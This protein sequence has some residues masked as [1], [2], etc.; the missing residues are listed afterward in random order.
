M[1]LLI[2]RRRRMFKLTSML[3]KVVAVFLILIMVACESNYYPK[4]HAYIRIDLPEKSY[5]SFDSNYPYSF[6]Y[7]VYATI[8]PN[9][10]QNA[11]PF[12]IDINF[13]QFQG[14]LHISYKTIDNNLAEYLEDS[15]TL[16]MKHIPKSS[17]IEN[18]MYENPERKV[19][20]LTYNIS[21]VNAASPYQFYLTDSTNH[22][23]RGALY[24]NVV[25]NND[26]LAPVIEFLKEDIN[27]LIETFEWKDL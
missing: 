22:F 4:P 19:Y 18:T 6:Q 11:D 21:G 10:V 2:S 23:L 13:P 25:P 14:K 16:V 8:L 5:Q 27:Y 17:G 24:F 12:W 1:L 3:T 7:P 9:T 15:R 26:S 20:G